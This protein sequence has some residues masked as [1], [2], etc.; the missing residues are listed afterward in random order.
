M[1]ASILNYGQFPKSRLMNKYSPYARAKALLIAAIFMLP[2]T[3]WGQVSWVRKE[4]VLLA[5]PKASAAALGPLSPETRA[6]IQRR[7]GLWL[8]VRV[9]EELGWVKL[10]AVRFDES[11]NFKTSLTNL[12]TGREGSGNNVAATGVRGLEAET[13]SLAEADYAAFARL[14]QIDRETDLIEE[15]GKIKTSRVIDNVSFNIAS[16]PEVSKSAESPVAHKLRSKLSTEVE[17][18]F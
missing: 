12:R 13:L 1:K 5:E 6:I 8:E 18:D 9:G 15:L 7:K 11:T 2:L 4:T 16:Q 17:D 3:A 10:S 14:I